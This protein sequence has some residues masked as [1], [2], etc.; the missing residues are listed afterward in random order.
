MNLMLKLAENVKESKHFIWF[1]AR[2]FIE[3]DCPYRASALAFATL[4]AIVP[5][6]AVTL[7]ILS[8]L[9]IIQNL[10]TPIQDFIFANFVPSTGKIIQDYLQLIAVQ[11]TK[12]SGIGMLFL[13]IVALLVMYTIE[14]TMN[15]IWRVKQSRKGLSAFLLYC[16]IFLAAPVLFGLSVVASSYFFSIPFIADHDIP[17]L[18]NYLP[19]LFSLAG[20]TFLYVVVPNCQVSFVHGLCGGLIATILF[21]SA[22][23]AFAYYLTNYNIYLLLYGAFATVPIFLV[24]IYWVWFI[25]LLGAEV[26]YAL[27]VNRKKP[28]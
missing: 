19:F 15:Q 16:A 28:N 17:F 23:L 1:V 9:P 14:H 4:I 18:L 21:E 26:S 8:T 12:L 3:D 24:W 22:K 6:L 13:V 25:S 5:F 2:H 11:A 27:S 7:A 10:A 20:F